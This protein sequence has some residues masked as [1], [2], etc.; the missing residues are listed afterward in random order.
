MWSLGLLSV[1]NAVVGLYGYLQ[2][3]KTAMDIA[4]KAAWL[5]AT[6]RQA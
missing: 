6:W 5:W 2:E 3:D 1:N 4:A